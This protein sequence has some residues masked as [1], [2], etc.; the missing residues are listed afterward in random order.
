MTDQQN[1]DFFFQT[2]NISIISIVQDGHNEIH[3]AAKQIYLNQCQKAQ[4]IQ[5]H[6]YVRNW[7]LITSLKCIFSC[8]FIQHNVGTGHKIP[9]DV[10]SNSIQFYLEMK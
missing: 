3:R 7:N 9:Y 2:K 5:Q 4:Y 10:Q 1:K 6:L 8:E